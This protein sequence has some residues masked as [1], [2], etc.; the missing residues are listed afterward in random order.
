MLIEFVK[1]IF[2]PVSEAPYT[3]KYQHTKS[4]GHES[5]VR[6]GYCGRIV[7]RYKTFISSRGFRV[8][9]PTILQQVDRKYIHTFTQKT[10]ACPSCARFR[11]IVQ[12][13]KS[14]RKKHMVR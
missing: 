2:M 4:R 9:D 10:Y 8:T 13:G 1:V 7:P 14:V 12:K 6:C 3:R 11:G 5:L